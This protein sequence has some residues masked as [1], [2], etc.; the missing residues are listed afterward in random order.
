MKRLMLAALAATLT[1][2][3][4]A[5]ALHLE[6][7]G[8]PVKL[9]ERVSLHFSFG[10]CIGRPGGWGAGGPLIKNGPRSVVI[11]MSGGG[12]RCNPDEADLF[13]F[14]ARVQAGKFVAK[15]GASGY[16][17]TETNHERAEG[18]LETVSKLTGVNGESCWHLA[19][20]MLFAPAGTFTAT[21]RRWAECERGTP[22]KSTVTGTWLM[23]APAGPVVWA[24][25]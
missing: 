12:E 6:A 20:K 2:S 25:G 8:K 16:T 21:G 7:G 14:E 3:A 11:E 17:L 22:K 15:E 9:G 1:L 24:S 13:A 19:P 5:E 23:E 18:V 4:P 10:E